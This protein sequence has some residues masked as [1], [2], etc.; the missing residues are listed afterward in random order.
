MPNTRLKTEL[1]YKPTDNILTIKFRNNSIHSDFKTNATELIVFSERKFVMIRTFK[2][3][4]TIA[5]VATSNL[6]SKK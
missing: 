5:C 6:V 3:D 2:T 4:T 1:S